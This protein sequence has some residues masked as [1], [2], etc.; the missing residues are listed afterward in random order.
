MKIRVSW[1]RF[2]SF[3]AIVF[4]ILAISGCTELIEITDE[5]IGYVDTHEG[6]NINTQQD[7]NSVVDGSLEVHFIDVGQADCILVKQNDE[8]MLID[9]GNNDDADFIKKYLDGL[10]I[11]KFKYVIGTH[12]HEDHIG[13]LDVVINNFDIEGI[14]M[15][16]KISTTKTFEDV[17]TAIENKK[18]YI[19][20]AKVGDK[21]TLG[22]AEFV[23]LA[24][25]KD[26][27]DE[28]N[29]ASVVIRLTYGENSFMFTGDA[30]VD[31]EEDIL[32]AGFKL[33]SD[34]LKF[35]HHG[36]ST[37]TSKAFLEAVDPK[38]GVIMCGVDNSYGHPHRETLS[39]IKD[40][41]IE[42][43]RTDENGTI[44][45]ISD[46]KDISWKV[47]VDVSKVSESDNG[48]VRTYVLN[49]SSKKF[50]YDSCS[51]AN[52]MSKANREEF[53]GFRDELIKKGYSACGICK[54]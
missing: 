5:V 23:I 22:D 32:K 24:P 13:S 52:S 44:V 51:G 17:V 46:G 31:S 4:M 47:D 42:T 38:Y 36:S 11:S 16:N 25:Y 53:I 48:D 26:Y 20:E 2:V 37:S 21:Y 45:A 54:P 18:L 28:T 9:A 27:G 15:P 33:E 3:M 43:Y 12:P 7:A 39:K 8:F 49:I 50:H 29:N 30:E 1:L 35:G 34:V 10:G 6:L 14:I 19:N 41:D 40:Y